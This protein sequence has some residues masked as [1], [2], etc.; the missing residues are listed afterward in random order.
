M[1]SVVFQIATSKFMTHWDIGRV[2][3]NRRGNV[4]LEKSPQCTEVEADVDS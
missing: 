2:R 4:P 3:L 1:M